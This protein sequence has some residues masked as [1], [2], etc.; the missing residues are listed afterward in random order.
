M[1][2]ETAQRR[3]V[4]A[5]QMAAG[6]HVYEREQFERTQYGWQRPR[7]IDIEKTVIRILGPVLD[8]RRSDEAVRAK[9]AGVIGAEMM[10][11]VGEVRIA[12]PRK[13]GMRCGQRTLH[14]LVIETVNP[15][16]AF[17]L[18]RFLPA[19]KEALKMEGRLQ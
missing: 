1:K 18:R 8:P 3:R 16:V 7:I 6:Q 12:G 11:W 2:A 13:D 14:R 4:G 17:E 15:A 10:K 19:L 5:L 9:I